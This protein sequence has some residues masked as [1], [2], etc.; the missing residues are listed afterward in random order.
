MGIA[1]AVLCILGARGLVKRD[2]P[3]G[4][5][6]PSSLAAA[7]IAAPVR[8]VEPTEESTPVEPTAPPEGA[9]VVTESADDAKR[10]SLAALEQGKFA[11][12]VAAGERATELDPTDA[13]SWLILGAAYQDQG[14]IVAARRAFAS[15]AKQATKGDVRE[16][17][18]LLQ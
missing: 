17:T 6:A 1:A 3:A 8:V 5:V 13:E 12:S 16:C 11:D 2:A 4:E 15:C 18:F 10:A 14:N 9:P 7:Q